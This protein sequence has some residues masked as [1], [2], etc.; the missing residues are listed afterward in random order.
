MEIF[1]REDLDVFTLPTTLQRLDAI[2]N[3]LAPKLS[4]LATELIDE[5]AMTT[6]EDLHAQLL[7]HTRRKKTPPEE[8]WVALGPAQRNYKNEPFFAVA[9]SN[10]SVQVRV[11]VWPEC[12]R[13]PAL[14]QLLVQR[15]EDLA[16]NTQRLG[17]LRE[18]IEWDHDGLP[19][20]APAAETLF[21]STL[22]GRVAEKKN[23]RFDLGV[24]WKG[25]EAL[26]LDK[27]AIAEAIAQLMPLYHL[28]AFELWRF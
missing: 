24:G 1:S 2:E 20:P 15:A 28:L 16:R 18:F 8:T 22:G 4:A 10:N 23:A 27:V 12:A 5:L 17:A 3:Q 11:Q 14:G 13:K 26:R 25:A 19:E 7:S 9:I 6:G 21:W